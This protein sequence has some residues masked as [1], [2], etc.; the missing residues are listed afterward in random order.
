MKLRTLL[1]AST[2]ALL[3][4]ALVVA[5]QSPGINNNFASVFTMVWEASTTK[6]TYSATIAYSLPAT[7]TDV[8]AI[9]GSATKTIRVRRV[10]IGGISNAVVTE[11]VAITRHAA[12][13]A[14]TN[15]ATMTPTKYDSQSGTATANLV[16]YFLTAP[17]STAIGTLTGTLIDAFVTFPNTTTGTGGSPQP[18]EFDFGRLGSAAV[19]RGV[20]QVLAVNMTGQDGGGKLSCTFEWTEE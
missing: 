7:P 4:S 14:L 1:A 18:R 11:A 6:P 5:A 3:S 20:S 16:D 13:A 8:C 19:L 17:S 15:G 9:A 12:Y 2:A 10:M